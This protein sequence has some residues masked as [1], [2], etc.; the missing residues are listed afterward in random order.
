MRILLTCGLFILMGSSLQAQTFNLVIKKPSGDYT[1]QGGT[2]PCHATCNEAGTDNPHPVNIAIG[3]LAGQAVTLNI[4]GTDTEKKI[5]DGGG[6]LSGEATAGSFS[7]PL[8][9]NNKWNLGGHFVVAISPNM[10]VNVDAGNDRGATF[11]VVATSEEELENTLRDLEA[12]T[13]VIGGIFGS[14]F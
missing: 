14:F 3:M 7:G 8:K 12:L 10:T 5:Y 2:V 6:T 11:E 1:H 4:N 9:P 13:Q